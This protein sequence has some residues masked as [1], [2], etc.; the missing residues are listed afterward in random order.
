MRWLV[1]GAGALGGYFGGRLALAGRDVTFLLR[2]RSLARVREHGLRI[3]SPMGDAHL[4]APRC[5]DHAEGA[6]DVVLLGCKAYDL[7]S[8]LDAIAPA[9]GPETAILPVLNG[10]HHIDALAARFG[11]GRVLGGVAMISATLDPDGTV[12]HFN[13]LHRLVYGELDGTRSPRIDAIAADFAGTNTDVRASDA[14]TQEMWD[15]W[16]FI[17]TLAGSQCLL[18]GAVG[19]IVKAGAL[20]VVTA[21][22]DECIAIA[23]SNGHAP[24]AEAQARMRAFVSSADSTVTAS[25]LKDV[26]RHAHCEGEQIV[27]DLLARAPAGMPTP[28]LHIVSAHLKTY[29][30]RRAR[31]WA[32]A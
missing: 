21:L 16:T 9:V 31:E 15:K 19:D 3:A 13:K 29:A 20:D 6:Y 14:I 17:A 30:V 32:A 25:M 10:M 8:A 23:G 4:A 26:E 27:G 18:R 12:H 24:G 5:T 7:D 22:L 1:L 28:V 2:Q 11:R